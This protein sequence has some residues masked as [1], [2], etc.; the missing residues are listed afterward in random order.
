MVSRRQGE[1]QARGRI[2]AE[3]ET[4]PFLMVFMVNGPRLPGLGGPGPSRDTATDPQT[5]LLNQNLTDLIKRA[6]KSRWASKCRT[7]HVP[8]DRTSDKHWVFPTRETKLQLCVAGV[9]V[10]PDL[11]AACRQPPG[12]CEYTAWWAEWRLWRLF[13]QEACRETDRQT[14]DR[15]TGWS[16]DISVKLQPSDSQ[17]GSV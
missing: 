2:K 6:V 3:G 10:R 8:A 14:A 4:V 17:E 9:C 1:C 16:R 5:C 12:R 15:E 11:S 7:G 13:I